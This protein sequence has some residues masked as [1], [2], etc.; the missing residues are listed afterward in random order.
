MVT[1]RSN[2]HKQIFSWKRPLVYAIF[3]LPPGIKGLISGLILLEICHGQKRR[4]TKEISY[5]GAWL[6][7]KRK[8]L[9]VNQIT[10]CMEKLASQPILF[11]CC[12]RVSPIYGNNNVLNI[13][14]WCNF[15]FC[16]CL[17]IHK[18]RRSNFEKTKDIITTK[19][20]VK[21]S[22]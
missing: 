11:A 5:S 14:I 20:A 22:N 10:E 9:Q 2:I 1:K 21:C 16:V 13:F 8:V 12:A 6:I 17:C 4:L 7:G 15:R 19:I 3:L 18:L